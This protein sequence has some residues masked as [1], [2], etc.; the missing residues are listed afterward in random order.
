MA[1]TRVW[2]SRDSR[3]KSR[4]AL[5]TLGGIFGIAVLAMALTI[6]GTVLGLSMGWPMEWVSVLLCVG[7]T[8]L[9]LVLAVGVGRRSTGDATVFF[10]TEEDRLF[11]MDVRQRTGQGWLGHS[12]AVRAMRTQRFLRQLTQSPERLS[13]GDE[14]LQVEG[15]KERRR[16]YALRCRVGRPGGRTVSA[17]YFLTKEMEDREELLRQLERREGW[18]GSPELVENRKPAYIL[19]SILAFCLFCA[20]SIC[21]HPAVGLLPGRIYGP[22]LGAAF[23]AVCCGVWFGLRQHRGP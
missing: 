8:A 19:L 14:I 20:L 22:C 13:G 10:L 12:H 2:I 7:V 11:V 5:R 18:N 21:S 23:G 3:R 4:Y 17:T 6:G 1:V 16:D 9:V 15:I